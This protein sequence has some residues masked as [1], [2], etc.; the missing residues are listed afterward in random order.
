MAAWAG[1]GNLTRIGF[2]WYNVVGCVVIVPVGMLISLLERKEQ[3]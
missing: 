3:L 2:L 1:V